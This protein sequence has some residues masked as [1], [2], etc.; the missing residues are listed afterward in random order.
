MEGKDELKGVRVSKRY[1]I[2]KGLANRVGKLGNLYIFLRRVGLSP[3]LNP[4]LIKLFF[5]LAEL[6]PRESNPDFTPCSSLYYSSSVIKHFTAPSDSAKN[7]I[8][9]LNQA[10]AKMLINENY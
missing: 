9:N 1:K 4:D 8:L 2:I 10:S 6:I 5:S 3:R 7:F